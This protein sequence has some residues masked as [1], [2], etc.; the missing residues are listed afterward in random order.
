MRKGPGKLRR[1]LLVGFDPVQLIV[2][3]LQQR[4]EGA[5]NFFADVFGGSILALKWH[6]KA[7]LPVPFEAA[8]AHML[9]PCS[10]GSLEVSQCVVSTAAVLSDI[11]FL[12]AGLVQDLIVLAQTP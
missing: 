10:D 12:G 5:A 2:Q 11:K 3:Q 1:E 4:F 8:K 6:E 9:E 7:F